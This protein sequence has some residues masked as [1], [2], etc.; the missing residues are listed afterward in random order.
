[1]VYFENAIADR[2]AM[3]ADPATHRQEF[4]EGNPAISP[5]GRWIA[6]ESDE[7]GRFEVYVRP[8]PAV[9]EGKWVISRAGGT[10][11][12]PVATLT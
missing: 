8:F 6:Y 1:M 10:R 11:P 4:A 3:L 2:V 7:S 12:D 9:D 5:D